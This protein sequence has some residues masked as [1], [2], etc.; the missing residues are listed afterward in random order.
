MSSFMLRFFVQFFVHVFSA[1]VLTRQILGIF[2]HSS[3]KRGA[4]AGGERNRGVA[5]LFAHLVD[6]CE[7][8]SPA[9][10]LVFV[11]Q[12]GLPLAAL[13]RLRIDAQQA[14]GFAGPVLV[15]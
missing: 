4:Q 14:N 10:G 7:S 3:T 2:M 12:V 15:K 9:L 1:R 13:E 5:V 8:I 6:G 11:E